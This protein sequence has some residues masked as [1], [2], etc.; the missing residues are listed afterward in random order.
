M[1]FLNWLV[2]NLL[3]SATLNDKYQAHLVFEMT[4]VVGEYLVTLMEVLLISFSLISLISI[5]TALKTLL[6]HSTSTLAL[7]VGN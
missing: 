1:K 2:K 7:Q 4:D 3:G 5:I 6:V